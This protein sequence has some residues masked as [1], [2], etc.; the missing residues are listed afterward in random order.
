[1]VERNREREHKY[2]RK[3]ES[4]GSILNKIGYLLIVLSGVFH[5]KNDG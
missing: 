1:M 4:K 3:R 5:I 2:K